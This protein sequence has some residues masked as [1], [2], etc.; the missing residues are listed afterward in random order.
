MYAD[1]LKGAGIAVEYKHYEG[2]AHEFFGMGAAVDK[3]KQ[4]ETDAAAALKA[5]FS[6]SQSKGQFFAGG[7]LSFWPSRLCGAREIKL[8]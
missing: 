2:M 4:A 5:A 3:A 8:S 7:T 1:K 6:R